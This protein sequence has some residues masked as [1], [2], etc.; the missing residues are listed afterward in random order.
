MGFSCPGERLEPGSAMRFIDAIIYLEP[1]DGGPRNLNAS[2][3]RKQ[4]NFMSTLPKANDLFETGQHLKRNIYPFQMKSMGQ[5]QQDAEQANYHK[6]T[7][8]SYKPKRETVMMHF[9]T[10]DL[11]Y[12]KFNNNADEQ[13]FNL[14]LFPL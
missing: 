5:T 11:V 12:D 3:D 2:P 8:V 14:N 4:N 9:E 1:M 6:Q 13:L 10:Q 7:D